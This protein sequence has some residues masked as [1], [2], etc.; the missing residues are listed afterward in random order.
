[1]RTRK[2]LLMSRRVPSRSTATVETS[3]P[4]SGGTSTSGGAP[5]A[6]VAAKALAAT[7]QA[8]TDAALRMLLFIAPLRADLK[9]DT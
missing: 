8:K 6:G 5:N 7:R 3:V 4:S 2:P 9:P 1:M